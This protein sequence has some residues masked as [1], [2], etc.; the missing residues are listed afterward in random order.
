MASARTF[1]IGARGSK[2]ARWQ[3]EWVG[4]QLRTRG[5]AVEI[6]EITTSGDV[7]QLGPVTAIGGVGVFTKEIQAAL[8][9]GDVDLAVHSLKD[10]PTQQVAGLTL[11]ATPP[12]ENPADAL[13]AASGSTLESLAPGSRVGTGS[14]RRRAQ[15]LA[16]RPDLVMLD[17]RGN[18]DTRLRKL[19]E[20]QYDAIVLAAAGL[21]RL[22]WADRITEMLAPPRVLPA[23]GQ[24]SLAIECR[25]NDAVTLAA[26]TPLDDPQ[27][28]AAVVA[29]RTLLGVLEG[30]CSAPIAAWGRAARGELRLDGLV[31]SLDGC[32]VLRASGE[33]KPDDADALGARIA[34]ELLQQG[35][36][37]I[38]GAARSG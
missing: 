14:Q 34:D 33:S 20:G 2:L 27:T 21:T 25:T 35:A 26:L 1:R 28:R 32:R 8:L 38:V 23:P 7:Q 9:A 31:A 13:I 30:G 17:I 36:A 37:A 29:E 5:V 24:G 12:R 19:D 6:V 11:A 18:V 10:L 16:L 15:L 3:S 4:E 22:G